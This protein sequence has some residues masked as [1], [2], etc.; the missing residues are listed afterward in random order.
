L[1]DLLRVLAEYLAGSGKRDARAEAL[2]QR[3][4][5]FLLKLPDLRADSGLSSIT[6][7]RSLGE[8]LQPYDL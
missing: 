6:R 8:A 4:I 7:L 1:K 2:E 3:A 5:Q